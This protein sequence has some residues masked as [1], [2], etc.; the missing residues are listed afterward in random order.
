MS[1]PELTREQL[2][3]AFKAPIE[4]VRVSFFYRLGLALV[5]FMMILLPLSYIA[6]IGLTIWGVVYHAT[7]HVGIM[8]GTGRGF[9]LRALLYVGPLLIGPIVIVFMIKPLL[10]R[11]AKPAVPVSVDP[12]SQPLL[13]ELVR[14]LCEVVGAPMPRQINIDC[15]V[16]ASASFRR[17]ALSMFGNDLLLTIGLPLV[18]GF[19]LRGLVGV[20]AHEFGHFAQGSGMRLT[21]VIRVINAWLARVVYERDAWD[22][23]LAGLSEGIDIRIGVIFYAARFV[24]WLVRRI[25]WVLMTI[26]HTV[27]MFMLRQMEYD[28]DQYEV[29]IAG[30]RGFRATHRSIVLLD[31]ANQAAFSSLE[32]AWKDRR[33]A[34]NLPRLVVAQHERIPKDL[35]ERYLAERSQGKGNLF[36]THP[37]DDRRLDAASRKP[38]AGVFDIDVPATA[39]FRDFDAVARRATVDYYREALEEEITEKNLLSVEEIT[40]RERAQAADQEAA[41]RYFGGLFAASRP[42]FLP[43]EA[44]TPPEDAA[45]A[46]AELR[47]ARTELQGAAAEAVPITK[48][49]VEQDE[50]CT[51]LAQ[52]ELVAKAKLKFNPAEFGLKGSEP[53]TVKNAR[54]SAEV[55]KQETERGLAE[56]QQRMVRRLTLAVRLAHA[57][58]VA[59]RLADADRSPA[60]IGR[61]LEALAGLR[62]A[63]DDL[64]RLADSFQAANLLLSNIEGNE[65]NE[66]FI[67]EIKIAAGRWHK[68]LS[69]LS[70]KLAAVPYPFDHAQGD[71]TVAQYA[72]E[73]IPSHEE[74]GDV[75]SAAGEALDRLFGLQSRILGQLVALAEK[76]EA[77]VADPGTPEQPSPGEKNDADPH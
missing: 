75:I 59:S 66:A 62:D 77:V 71:L 72:I 5:C 74:I 3:A 27:S 28:A 23:K 42:P 16:N 48:D 56:I 22:E 57:P 76:V 55:K 49:L 12:K 24:V 11:S 67:G 17:G 40:G 34:D 25:L 61:Q 7:E 50:R 13:F 26:G 9:L 54:R 15:E 19:D 58:E 29:C 18:A 39:L 65:E 33:L 43:P 68:L 70:G 20:L 36:D 10:A 45:A 32:D 64:W 41:A 63:S 14:K 69:A 52:M 6:L 2:L 44:A 53:L 60:E 73:K 8:T 4:P 37:P 31:L 35:Q 46:A 30:N 1:A 47:G 21:Y 38:M 51:L